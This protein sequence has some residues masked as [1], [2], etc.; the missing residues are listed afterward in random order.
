LGRRDVAVVEIFP[1][2]ERR[3]HEERKREEEEGTME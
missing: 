1:G 3:D 2:L